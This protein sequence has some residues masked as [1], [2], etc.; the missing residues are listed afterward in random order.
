MD[1]FQAKARLRWLCQDMVDRLEEETRPDKFGNIEAH[2]DEAGELSSQLGFMSPPIHVVMFTK[3][4]HLC[5]FPAVGE[6]G[7]EPIGWWV[8]QAFGD[9]CCIRIHDA[10]NGLFYHDVG[11]HLLPRKADE[12][13]KLVDL[14][15]ADWRERLDGPYWYG[16][17]RSQKEDRRIVTGM[18]KRWVKTI[19]GMPEV[20]PEEASSSEK[21]KK[22]KKKRKR[23][24]PPKYDPGEDLKVYKE[25]NRVKGKLGP[26]RKEFAARHDLT[27]KGFVNL[28]DRVRKR[29]SSGE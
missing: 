20:A 22:S 29:Q 21:P 9:L 1:Y 6:T 7:P 27:P 11:L 12:A 4:D 5:F 2:A 15:P 13:S 19:D 23:G 3:Q 14:L 17:G 24:A 10:A 26:G 18:L 28:L 8:T 16:K 25:W